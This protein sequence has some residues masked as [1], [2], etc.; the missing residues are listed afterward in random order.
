MTSR[1]TRKLR[2]EEERKAKKAAY[3]ASLA[4][5]APFLGEPKIQETVEFTP[6]FLAEARARRE[7]IEQRA[8][9]NR[10]NSLRST[11]PVTPEGKL[12]SSRNSLK[13]GLASGTLIIPGE[14]PAAFESLLEAL[15]ADHQPATATEEMLIQE[16]AQSYWLSQRA[17]R[18]QNDCFTDHGLD[19]KRLSLF[20][21]YHSTH[22]RAFHKA[23]NT[24]LR[25]QKDRRKSVT[26]QPTG[27]V[28]QS[29]I[30]PALTAG[31]V[32]QAGPSIHLESHFESL[33]APQSCPAEAA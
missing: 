33:N 9:I 20:L 27:F 8:A 6:E 16:M 5:E 31:F 4:S 25:L 21:R 26:K 12:A 2:R 30:Q 23:L 32:S 3:K 28:P 14:D 7:R 22:Q 18:L 24:L 11:G 17:L 29:S 19:E 10:A 1:H 13:H 15:L